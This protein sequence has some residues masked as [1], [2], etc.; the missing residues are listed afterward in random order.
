MLG[1]NIQ[2]VVLTNQAVR[3]EQEKGKCSEVETLRLDPASRAGSGGVAALLLHQPRHRTLTALI[4]RGP[5]R[6]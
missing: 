2:S 5:H 4:G 6:Y 1:R 3:D